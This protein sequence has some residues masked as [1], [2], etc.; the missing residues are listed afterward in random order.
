[1]ATTTSAVANLSP[2]ELTLIFMFLSPA[3]AFFTKI[4]NPCILAI[5]S[6]VLPMYQLRLGSGGGGTNNQAGG[7]NT[8]S[9]TN[10]GNGGSGE[11]TRD[12]RLPPPCPIRDC[13]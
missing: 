8:G 10:G 3:F 1:M 12:S 9:N 7:D 13:T 6:P 2:T 5:P 11:Q 4:I